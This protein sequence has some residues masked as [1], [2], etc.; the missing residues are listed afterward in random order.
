MDRTL[1]L[2]IEYDG[3]DYAGWQNQPNGVAVQQ[4]VEDAVAET[5]GERLAVVGSGRTDA[6]VHARGQVAHLRLS[7]TSNTIPLEKVAIAL[8]TRL[9][10]DVRIRAA[11]PVPPTFHATRD[12]VWREYVY[13]IATEPTVFTRHFA[14]HPDLPYNSDVLDT[15][16]AEF[17]GRFDFTTFSKHNPDTESYVCDLQICRVE[18]WPDRY[19]VRLR[20]DRFVYGMCRSIVGTIMSVARGRTTLK[21]IRPALD[22][23][24]RDLQPGLAPAHGLVLNAVMYDPPLFH[25]QPSY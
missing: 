2:L 22:A 20:A 13:F 6:G 21:E 17:Q 1:A 16:A 10:Y 18:R 11:T 23:R 3:A 8:N 7:D 19:V 14:W 5:F 12:P 25:D 9:P 24:D 15:A 4:V